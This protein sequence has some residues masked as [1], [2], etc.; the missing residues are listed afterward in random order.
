MERI[1]WLKAKRKMPKVKARKTKRKKGEKRMPPEK[2]SQPPPDSPVAK[3]P[4]VVGDW[5]KPSREAA[6]PLCECGKPVAPGQ[7]SVCEE[8][9][10]AK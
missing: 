3:K 2:P 10:R 9:I 1:T 7:S 4:V 8:H 6:G 5:S